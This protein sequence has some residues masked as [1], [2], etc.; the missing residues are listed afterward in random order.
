MQ[1]RALGAQ[2][3]IEGDDLRLLNELLGVSAESQG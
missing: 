1:E 2:F 3:D